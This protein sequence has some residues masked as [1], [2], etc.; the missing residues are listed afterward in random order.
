MRQHERSALEMQAV[1]SE[2][3]SALFWETWKEGVGRRP[4]LTRKSLPCTFTRTRLA[5]M[6]EDFY[7]P[8]NPNIFVCMLHMYL[9]VYVYIYIEREAV[10]I[11]KY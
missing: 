6:E 11:C 10:R 4:P 7:F 2:R 5:Q 3:E 1:Y 9:C 8:V